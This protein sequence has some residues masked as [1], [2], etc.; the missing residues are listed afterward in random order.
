MSK[1][2]S[3]RPV[4]TLKTAV[5]L[6]GGR[7]DTAPGARMRT[8]SLLR[9][10][11]AVGHRGIVVLVAGVLSGVAVGAG[12]VGT[13]LLVRYKRRLA[14][15][16]EWLARSEAWWMRNRDTWPAAAALTNSATRS[17]APGHLTS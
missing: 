4:R 7:S 1:H 14:Q 3:V 6:F 8:A 13:G 11:K 9:S 16:A 12:A 15:G 5:E 2:I 10:N 17:P